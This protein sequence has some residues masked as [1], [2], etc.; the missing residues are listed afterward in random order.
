MN[1]LLIV[2]AA[3]LTAITAANADAA[4]ADNV[5]HWHPVKPDMLNYYGMNNVFIS[6]E[7]LNFTKTMASV[8]V[9]TCIEEHQHWAQMILVLMITALEKERP[10]LKGTPQETFMTKAAFLQARNQLRDQFF[11]Q[12]FYADLPPD[13][14]FGDHAPGVR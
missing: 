7:E 5:R 11:F 4:N 14:H 3:L 2:G 10:D 9:V 12:L 1:K 13:V 6:G 8:M